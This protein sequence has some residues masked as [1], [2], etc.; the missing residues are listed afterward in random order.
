MNS[1]VPRPPRLGRWAG[2]GVAG[3]FPL[4]HKNVLPGRE[5]IV[6]EILALARV[7]ITREMI[8][9]SISFEHIEE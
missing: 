2:R 3:S 6:D 1:R 8:R 4:A 9:L 5:E 7:G